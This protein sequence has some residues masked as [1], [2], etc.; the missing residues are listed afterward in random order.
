MADEMTDGTGL[1]RTCRY[2]PEAYE[3]WFDENDVEHETDVASQECGCFYCT[4]CGYA[5]MFGPEG[6][7]GEDPPYKAH[8]RYCPGCGA[9]VVE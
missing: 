6:W 8:F 4:A 7:F 3:I 9:R 1:E 2:L 5:M